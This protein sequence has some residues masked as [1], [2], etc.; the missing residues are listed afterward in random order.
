MDF[1]Y[2]LFRKPTEE[3]LLN[4]EKRLIILVRLKKLKDELRK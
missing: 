1:I 2:K 4:E 3:D